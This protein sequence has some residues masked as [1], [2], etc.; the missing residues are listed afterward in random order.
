MKVSVIH[1]SIYKYLKIPQGAPKLLEIFVYY[2][3]MVLH[4]VILTP[5][6]NKEVSYLKE[7][8]LGGQNHIPHST[9]LSVKSKI[10]LPYYTYL[11]S[12]GTESVNNNAPKY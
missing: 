3:T 6:K 10:E 1:L 9:S 11:L 12:W 7:A 4:L 8:I 2:I 5:G